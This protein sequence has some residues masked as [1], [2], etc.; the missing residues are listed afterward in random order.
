MSQSE[1][2][3]NDGKEKRQ[4]KEDCVRRPCL[5]TVKQ[6]DDWKARILFER[7]SARIGYY[8]FS[9]RFSWKE[10]SIVMGFRQ[11]FFRYTWSDQNSSTSSTKFYGVKLNHFA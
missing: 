6:T 4:K 11:C 7:K 2:N 10:A 9:Q 5:L 1:S 3:K 8:L